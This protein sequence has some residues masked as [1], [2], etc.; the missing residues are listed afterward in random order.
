[1]EIVLG[2]L[3]T[4]L[5]VIVGGVL[6][7]FTS[8]RAIDRQH[9][10]DRSRLVHEKLEFIAQVANPN[11]LG[12]RMSNLY[13][14]AI[15]KVEAGERYRPEISLPFAKLEM[16]LS[17]YAPELKPEYDRL[18][19]LRD[20]MGSTLVD[21]ASGWVPTEKTEKQALNEKLLKASFDAE[22]ICERIIKG[23]SELGRERLALKAEQNHSAE[24]RT[25][26]GK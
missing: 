15:S 6:Q 9:E 19:Q 23:A 11:D 18:L 20:D 21:L 7:H 26:R 2:A 14:G 8:Q 25:S 10:W 12:E 3:T 22:N 17:F 16:L 4:L 13:S 24:T 1:M 5:G